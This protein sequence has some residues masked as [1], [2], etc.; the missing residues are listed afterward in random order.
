MMPSDASST[1]ALARLLVHG[2]ALPLLMM[3]LGCQ[4]D[5]RTHVCLSFTV[6]ATVSLFTPSYC[7]LWFEQDYQRATMLALA[8]RID[9]VM[10]TVMTLSPATFPPSGPLDWA[11]SCWLVMCSLTW[12]GMLLS[13][14][15][16]YF[17]EARARSAYLLERCAGWNRR[18]LARAVREA[19]IVAV[20]GFAV[21][22]A[23]VYATLR[24]VAE[25]Q[26]VG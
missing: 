2:G 20:W 6:T 5:F 23:A 11:S 9:K 13:C 19:A 16:I 1:G 17:L 21:M 8:S 18:Q 10:H 25:G 14:A 12:G 24:M 3:H 15:L 7:H 4:V 26:T 22:L